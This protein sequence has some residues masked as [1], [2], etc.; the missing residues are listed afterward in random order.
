[1]PKQSRTPTR[2]YTFILHELPPPL[3]CVLPPFYREDH[4]LDVCEVSRVEIRGASAQSRRTVLF[5]AKFCSRPKS[6]VCR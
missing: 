5:V 6:F 1:M 2:L 4:D 3:P